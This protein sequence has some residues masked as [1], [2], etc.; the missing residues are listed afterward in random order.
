MKTL[1]DQLK[2][3][4][5]VVTGNGS[6]CVVS[7][8]TAEL[9]PGQRLWTNSGCAAMGYDLPG[10]IGACKASG[11]KPV[12]CLAGDG[13]I[14]MNLQELQTIVGNKLPIKIFILNNSGY[15]SIFQSQRNFF[16]GVEVGGGPKSGVTFPDFGR[17]SEAFGL[18]YCRCG[19]HQEMTQAIR[20]TLNVEGP[21]VCEI[22][23]DEN[24][25]FAP[26]LGAKQLPDGRIIS[27]A[28]EDLSP[29][30]SREQLKDNMLIGLIED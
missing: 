16:A 29:F 10:A 28:L 1:F 17:L 7:F 12:V 13:S 26:K 14:M 22:M 30:L 27:P 19:T 20:D 4:Q 3:D 11:N 6:A 18:P 21:T 9:K 24:I 5:I 23:L 15:V 8:Q 2:E 25:P